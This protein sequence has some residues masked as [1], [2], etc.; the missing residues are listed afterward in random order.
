MSWRDD[1]LI[2]RNPKRPCGKCENTRRRKKCEACD[3]TGFKPIDLGGIWAGRP[4]ML[5]CGGPSLARTP[6]TRLRERG[7]VS[8]GVNNAAAYAQTTA[9]TFGDPQWKFHHSIFFDPKCM[10]FAPTAKLIRKVRVKLPDGTYRFSDRTVAECPATFGLGRTGRLHPEQ[11]LSTEYA[12]WGHGGKDDQEQPFRRIAS[13]LLGLRLLHYLGCSRIYMI[14]VDFWTT[15]EQPYA[16]G[17]QQSSGNKIWWKIDR[18][19]L[20]IR[21]EFDRSGV[22]VW[23]CNPETR[24]QAFPFASWTTA[25]ADC[26]R[27]M[28]AGEPDLFDWYSHKKM[29]AD[30]ERW[31]EPVPVDDI[32]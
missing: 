4:G 19:L 2:I 17:G 30:R 16:W 14:G 13:M 24:S 32:A 11:F 15:R 27:Y 5:V 20:D 29:A 22:P 28:P 10:V 8:V 3:F 21:G 23:N 7:V 18:M 26:T 31:P 9:A 1:P 25:I 12:H 6:V